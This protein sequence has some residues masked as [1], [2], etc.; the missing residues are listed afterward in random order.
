MG[1]RGDGRSGTNAGRGT[2]RPAEVA[3]GTGGTGGARVAG[4]TGMA[5]G[6]G[7]GRFGDDAVGAFL[8]ACRADAAAAA[9]RLLG[10][11]RG[12]RA[13]YERRAGG[14]DYLVELHA[15][16]GCKFRVPVERLPA[17]FRLA[18]DGGD[19][20]ILA[21]G[22][23]PGTGEPLAATALLDDDALAEA[24][25]APEGFEAFVD[26]HT[27]VRRGWR[28]LAPVFGLRRAS[29][30]VRPAGRGAAMWCRFEVSVEASPG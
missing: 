18:P 10:G 12:V 30:E 9:V 2:T 16:A 20:E 8:D 11:R 7:G 13:E 15:R 28:E 27:L 17:G 6:T 1:E 25:L 21:P 23:E 14:Q 29:F 3:G 19:V 4:A 22:H 5:G 24:L 26:E